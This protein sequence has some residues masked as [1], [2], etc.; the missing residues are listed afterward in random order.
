MDMELNLLIGG[1]GGPEGCPPR[2]TA[3]KTTRCIAHCAARSTPAPRCDA[4]FT[5]VRNLGLMVKTG[6]YLLD[7]ALQRAIDQGWHAG[8]RIYPAGHAVTP[9]GGHLDPTVFQRLAPGIMPLSRGRG[10]RQRRARRDRLRSLSDPPRRQA[11]QGV[12]VGRGDV[13]QHRRRAPS[14]TPT[15]SSPRS[16]TKPT[17]PASGSPRT[18]SATPRSGR[19]SVPGSTASSTA[20]SLPTR[21]SR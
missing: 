16:P 5:T 4:G 20:S 9:Y 2:C 15:R 6:G 3:F 19:A 1:P 21:P 8:P 17:A 18:P 10:H 14:S 13:A 11:D 7:V 12:G